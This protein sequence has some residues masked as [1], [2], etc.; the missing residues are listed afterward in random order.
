[1]PNGDSGRGDFD[2]VGYSEDVARIYDLLRE[3]PRTFNEIMRLTG[4]NPRRVAYI[5]NNPLQEYVGVWTVD[6]RLVERFPGV[7]KYERYKLHYLERYKDIAA[8]RRKRRRVWMMSRIGAECARMMERGLQYAAWRVWGYPRVVVSEF[9]SP[10]PDLLVPD[11]PFKDHLI[12]EISVRWDNP[13]DDDYILAKMKARPANDWT[14][15]I[16]SPRIRGTTKERIRSG[17]YPNI[18][19]V[20]FPPIFWESEK[21]F[22]IFAQFRDSV[23]IFK[24]A[25]REVRVIYYWEYIGYL[26]NY[27]YEFHHRRSIRGAVGTVG[28][29][30]PP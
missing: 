4:V 15:I 11:P 14:I 19:W 1:M 5:L 13:L 22:P 2:P 24:A 7:M 29:P 12:A 9:E 17:L 21:G 6:S 8:L 23:P 16:F 3:E 18:L 27:L 20:E 26:Q 10:E 28:K 25:G 30:L